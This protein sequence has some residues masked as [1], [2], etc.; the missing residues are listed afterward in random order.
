MGGKTAKG[1]GT[2][3]IPPPARDRESSMTTRQM[4]VGLLLLGSTAVAAQ[5]TMKAVVVRAETAETLEVSCG[6]PVVSLQDAE[7]VLAI[8]D[9]TQAA[10]LR[11]RLVGAAT[12]ACSKGIASIEVTRGGDGKSLTWKAVN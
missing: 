8:N 5:T 2:D 6:N 11:K 9:A 4:L 10:G 7:R 12:A 1:F 3:D